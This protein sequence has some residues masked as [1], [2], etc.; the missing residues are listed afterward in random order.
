MMHLGNGD[1]ENMT[2]ISSECQQ[3]RQCGYAAC[4]AI[5]ITLI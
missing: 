5:N 3:Y 1:M 2:T 4:P